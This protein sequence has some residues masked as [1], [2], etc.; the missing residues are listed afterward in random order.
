MQ[1]FSP[2]FPPSFSH[3]ISSPFLPLPP[4]LPQ[5]LAVGQKLPVS[6]FN[7]KHT[8]CILYALGVGMS[9]KDPD[10][11]RY[12]CLSSN[13]RWGGEHVCVCECV[14]GY[15]PS[16]VNA[17]FLW[18]SS[19]R[20]GSC[21]KVIQTSAASPPSGSFPPRRPWWTVVWLPSLDSTL[22]SHRLETSYRASHHPKLKVTL[23]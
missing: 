3:P 7:F 5:A 17:S 21:M 22:I 4:P 16:C 11:L 19:P 13:K 12:V 6:T 8:Q 1:P 10:H 23:Q 18:C 14:G 20:E 2:L 15:L 9:T